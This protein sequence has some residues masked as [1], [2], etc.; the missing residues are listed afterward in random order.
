MMNFVTETAFQFMLSLW[1]LQAYGIE[2]KILVII[3]LGLSWIS[4]FKGLVDRIAFTRYQNPTTCQILS[5]WTEW[6]VVILSQ[7]VITLQDAAE[8]FN[9]PWL[10]LVLWIVIL[11]STTSINFLR[12]LLPYNAFNTISNIVSQIPVSHCFIF[13]TLY[14]YSSQYWILMV[15]LVST[16]TFLHESLFTLYLFYSWTKQTSSLKP[17]MREKAILIFALKPIQQVI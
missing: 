4:L 12:F 17:H 2:G 11:V 6:L 13:L 8:E 1:V 14:A 3:S 7:A 15:I 9:A 5:T 16:D 10:A